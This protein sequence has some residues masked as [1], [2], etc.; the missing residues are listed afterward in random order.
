MELA[1]IEELRRLWAEGIESGPGKHASMKD[2]ITE[3][4]RRASVPS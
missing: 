3:A 2:I 1:D 4:R